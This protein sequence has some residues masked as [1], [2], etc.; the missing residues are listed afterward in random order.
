[1]GVVEYISRW[2]GHADG[3]I[4][5]MHLTEHPGRYTDIALFLYRSCLWHG[6]VGMG[7]A[8]SIQ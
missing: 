7:T 2:Q 5:K 1:M 4:F 6:R 3:G 8:M